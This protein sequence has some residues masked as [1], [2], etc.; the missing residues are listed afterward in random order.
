MDEKHVSENEIVHRPWWEPHYLS[1]C[2]SFY[3]EETN[4]F[5]HCNFLYRTIQRDDVD[6]LDY[7]WL[8]SYYKRTLQEPYTEEQRKNFDR[9]K[10]FA[11][12]V[13]Y[14]VK[15]CPFIY[16]KFVPLDILKELQES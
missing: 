11:V 7:R 10:N 14:A 13:F 1:C 8:Y 4:E 5:V 6:N 3:D 12:R 15:L 2:D 9:F 16:G